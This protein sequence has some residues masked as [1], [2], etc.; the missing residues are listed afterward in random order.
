[1][2]RFRDL[3]QRL[4]PYADD[5]NLQRATEILSSRREA[6]RSDFVAGLSVVVLNLDSPE[7]LGSILRGFNLARQDFEARGVQLELIVG[8]TGSADPRTLRLMNEPHPGLTFVR[9]LQYQFSRNNNQLF[10]LVKYATTLF[11]NNDVLIEGEPSALARAYDVHRKTGEIVSVVFDFPDGNTQHRGVEF[12]TSPEH[13]GLPFHPGARE[14][15]QHNIGAESESSAVTGAFLMVGSA[16][17]S[18][19]GGFDE[20]YVAEC[21]DVDLCL[22]ANRLGV[23][24]RVVDV[25]PLVHIENATRPKGEENWADRRRFIRRWSSYIETL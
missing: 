14:P 6:R 5:S 10:G 15:R 11:L 16:L 17:F 7:L 20:R 21:Q 24:C 18:R 9:D 3:E 12:L 13:F 1:M 2:A 8:D 22:R 4:D 23:H 19:L 25:G